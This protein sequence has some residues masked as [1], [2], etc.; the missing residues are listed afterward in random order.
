MK[1]AVPPRE[2]YTLPLKTEAWF[3]TPPDE[4]TTRGSSTELMMLGSVTPETGARV[5]LFATPP[6]Q[7]YRMASWLTVVL[8]ATPPC[9]IYIETLSFPEMTAVF[10]IVA[11]PNNVS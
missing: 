3:M 5:V 8:F 1:F 10:L 9:W 11:R 2:T 4:T 6:E 7:I